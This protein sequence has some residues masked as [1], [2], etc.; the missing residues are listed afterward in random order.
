[1]AGTRTG[2][3]PPPI[4]AVR[5][6][7]ITRRVE[8]SASHVCSRPDLSEEENRA[9]YG[10]AARRHGHGHNYAVEVTLAGEPDPVTGMV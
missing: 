7:L 10:D 1:M 5:E 6:M 8:F 4:G 9:L 3:R 2:R